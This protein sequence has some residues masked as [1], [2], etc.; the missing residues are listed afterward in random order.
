[1]VTVLAVW[2]AIVQ[3]PGGVDVQLYWHTTAP[4]CPALR[5]IPE[6]RVYLEPQA[7]AAFR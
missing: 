7:A 4:S 2:D 1:M 5:T 6:S 3:F